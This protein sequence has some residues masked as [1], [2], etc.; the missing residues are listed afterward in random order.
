MKVW[1]LN[2]DDVRPDAPPMVAGIYLRISDDA[3]GLELGVK[4]QEKDTIALA[5]RH[6]ATEVRRYCDN[7]IGASTR[8]RKKRPEFEQLLAD[9]E[10]GA[11]QMIVYYSNSRLTRRPLEYEKIISLV[12]RTRVR[13]LSVASGT[14]DLTTADG[15]MVGRVL[16]AADAAEAERIAERVARKNQE[17]RERNLPHH[18]GPHLLGYLPPDPDK[19]IGVLTHLDPVACKFIRKG[20]EMILA[21]RG[22]TAVMDYWNREGF[23]RPNGQ[24]WLFRDDVRRILLRPKAAGLV[25]HQ[26]E[27][28]GQGD[29][30]AVLDRE[31]WE[32]LNVVLARKIKAK[33]EQ[34]V[35]KY[36]LSGLIRC[37]L[38]GAALRIRFPG[39]NRAA[40]YSCLKGSGGCGK[41]SRNKQWIEDMVSAYVL[42]RIEI[43]YETSTGDEQ[44]PDEGNQVEEQ[45]KQLEGRIR[46]A[47]QQAAAG[48]LPMADAGAIMS[49]IRDQIDELKRQ[50]ARILTTQRQADTSKEDLIRTWLSDEPSLAEARRTIAAKYVSR[51]LIH[52]L[53]HGGRWLPHMY[54]ADSISILPA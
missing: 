29:W 50:K 24:P 40:Q 7:D 27:I 21:G 17:R 33:P 47:R 15:R 18:G 28:I 14:V 38:C 46:E 34:R 39:Q 1:P 9:T 48:T 13:L 25:A 4:R 10:S 32:A 54:P 44:D 16:A 51:V 53:P 42:D 3:E 26:G 12:E 41:L 43:E 2:N 19:G 37:G 23:T 20:A 22:L 30:P 36:H 31:T 52:P 49:A 6:G 5:V 45:I 35:R 8:S 11:I